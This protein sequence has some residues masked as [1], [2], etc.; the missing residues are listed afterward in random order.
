MSSTPPVILITFANAKP[1]YLKA[2]VE[3]RKSIKNIFISL[4]ARGVLQVIP[5]SDTTTKDIALYLSNYRERLIIFHF[6]GHANADQLFLTQQAAYPEGLANL[7]GN[8]PLLKLVFLNGCYTARHAS[9]LMQAGVKAV[10]ATNFPVKDELAALFS[11][12]FYSSLSSGNYSILDAYEFACDNIKMHS[13]A[14]R[15]TPVRDSV[16][17]GNNDTSIPDEVPWLLFINEA[18]PDIKDWTISSISDTEATYPK[19]LTRV[20]PFA[21]EKEFIG[22]DHELL[23][24]RQNIMQDA[25]STLLHGMPGI[26][27]TAFANLFV[28]K[29]EGL[30]K[31][32]IWIDNALHIE[33]AFSTNVDLLTNLKL[34]SN[35]V[36]RSSISL[37]EIFRRLKPLPGPSLLVLDGVDES[38]LEYFH[39]FPISKSWKLLAIS[40]QHIIPFNSFLLSALPPH[41]ATELF[42]THYGHEKNDELVES[43]LALIDRHTLCTEFIAKAAQTARLQLSTVIQSIEDSGVDLPIKA[44]T[45]LAHNRFQR[46]GQLLPYLTK[47]FNL[48]D[49]PDEEV[50][51][52]RQ[53]ALLPSVYIHYNTLSELV[54][55]TKPDSS[56]SITL[57]ELS[58]KHLIE[59]DETTDSYKIGAI[60]QEA[61]IKEKS[62]LQ[63]A[64][65]Q[66][67]QKIT[68]KLEIDQS[69]ESYIDKLNWIKY[70]NRIIK[71]FSTLQLA[72]PPLLLS[73]LGVLYS[74]IGKLDEAEKLNTQAVQDA[75]REYG[76]DTP[77]T[78]IT[79]S[80]LGLTL[81]KQGQAEQAK[82]IME[83]A[84]AIEIANSGEFHEAIA[85]RRS[86]LALILYDLNLY[87]KAKKQMELALSISQNIFPPDHP[88]INRKLSSLAVILMEL[89][90]YSK[91]IEL[92]EKALAGDQKHLDEFH[93]SIA[94]KY[95]NLAYAY[96]Q[97]GQLDIAHEMILA[98]LAINK[99]NLG[100]NHPKIGYQYVKLAAIYELQKKLLPAQEYL[101][102]ALFIFENDSNS[103]EKVIIKIK[104]LLEEN[105]R[106]QEEL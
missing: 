74:E 47:M 88:S 66:L 21:P 86:N 45:V 97:T 79:L 57:N 84:I 58:N 73:N 77:N 25:N 87:K 6:G 71:L 75:R 17:V 101:E 68:E 10:I 11:S 2:L 61:I 30:F 22:R 7:L 59:Y 98:S 69:H 33:Q 94:I 72:M 51:L 29:Y 67:S 28:K 65:I 89:G 35:D 26:G 76:E 5:E 83:K 24:L 37:T 103:S 4:D 13:K 40:R 99:S 48:V 1:P 27:K 93:P 38:I 80:N 96:Q 31:H 32:I 34:V 95:S 42:Y 56:V 60:L 16:K 70:A 91:S 9:L 102:L 12:Y 105:L 64:L 19:Y 54:Q 106:A 23:K 8:I 92:L 49:L 90:A 100:A 44:R 36:L 63:A 55:L 82:N 15:N 20:P 53:M 14:Y 78:A 43:L 41:D 62:I 3:E 52:L 18:Q 50:E 85:V 46:V 81:L 39:L 104:H